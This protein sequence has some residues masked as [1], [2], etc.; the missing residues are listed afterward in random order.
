[1]TMFLEEMLAIHRGQ[2]LELLW[3]ESLRCPSEEEYISMANNKTSGIVRIGVRLLIG[4]GTQN[5]GIDYV[6]LANLIG[7]FFQIRDDL[8]NLDSAEYTRAKGFADD[9]TEGK[10]SFPIIHGIRTNPSNRLI[11]DVLKER[12][13][14][15]SLKLQVIEYLRDETKSFAYSLSVLHALESEIRKEIGRLGGNVALER[16]VDFLHVDPPNLAI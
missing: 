4:C 2:G 15:S 8:M 9:L 13:T 12:T 14:A 5:T 16:I 3:R 6:P 10:F 7:L 11:L 1:M